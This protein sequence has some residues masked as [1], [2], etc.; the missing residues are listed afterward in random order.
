ELLADP[1]RDVGRV[2]GALVPMAGSRL[3]AALG[4]TT[5][6]LVDVGQLIHRHRRSAAREEQQREAGADLGAPFIPST[7]AAL[8]FQQHVGPFLVPVMLADVLVPPGHADALDAVPSVKL[9]P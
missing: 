6:G 2:A 8:L 3:S 7:V 4:R 5:G 9:I 1:A